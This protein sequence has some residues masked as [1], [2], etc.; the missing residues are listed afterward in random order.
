AQLS[1][2]DLEL[3]DRGLNHVAP[4]RVRAPCRIHMPTK[5]GLRRHDRDALRHVTAAESRQYAA[6]ESGRNERQLR[7]VLTGGM[8]DFWFVSFL[9]QRMHQEVMAEPRRP[10]DPCLAAKIAQ[11][12]GLRPGEAMLRRQGNV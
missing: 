1:S 10:D 6:A 7:L 9:T 11:L 5:S 2:G 8:R 4:R 12:D 3:L